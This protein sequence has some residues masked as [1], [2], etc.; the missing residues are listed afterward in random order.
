MLI[1][2]NIRHLPGSPSVQMQ[3]IPSRD[4]LNKPIKITSDYSNLFIN[5]FKPDSM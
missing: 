3:E 4:L 5:K 1:F 2:E